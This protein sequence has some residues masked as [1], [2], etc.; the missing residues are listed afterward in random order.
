[1]VTQVATSLYNKLAD[2]F[3]LRQAGDNDS[4]G[5]LSELRSSAFDI[6]KTKG[7]P[8]IKE[9]DWRFTS[10]VPFLDVDYSFDPGPVDEQ[11]LAE[12][13]RKITSPS[14]NVY[15]VVL[16]NGSIHPALSSLPDPGMV[17]IRPLK[18]IAQTAFFRDHLSYFDHTGGSTLNALN[19]AFF[20]DGFYFEVKKGVTV[21]KP[22]E[23]IH[24]YSTEKN[25]FLQ[26]RHLLII[27]EHAKAE[28]I[29][30]SIVLKNDTMIFVNSVLEL[31][32]KENAQFVHYHLQSHNPSE[33][34]L[35]YNHATQH[36]NSRYDNF[37]FSLP[38][39]DLIRNNLEVRLNG[40]ATETHLYGLYLVGEH[41]LIDNHTSIEHLFPH[42][43]SNEIYKGVLMDNG[44]AVFNGK[45]FVDREAQQTNAFQQN[46]NLLLSEKAQIYAKPQLEIFA[47]DVKCSHGCTIGQFDQESLFYL[48]SRGISEE[49]ARKMLVE[50]FMFDVT[51]KIENM[52]V[53]QYVQGLIYEKMGNVPEAVN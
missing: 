52:Q 46:N 21:D 45:V 24:I 27:N 3:E 26:P 38:G 53:K 23:V 34:W 18:D 4:A 22:I 51:D 43:Q 32:I 16:V 33:R 42:C 10:L 2:E 48:R 39:A 15:Q 50:A 19:T 47:D 12:A 36:R 30:T 7:F 13:V 31:L 1:M 14:L 5:I 44:K 25:V 8:S 41:Q 40:T 49:A 11:Q 37:T 20:T 17:S 29:E 6:F 35:H 28:I 9:E